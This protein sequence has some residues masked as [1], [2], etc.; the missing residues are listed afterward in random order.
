MDVWATQLLTRDRP[1]VPLQR[2]REPVLI[3]VQGRPVSQSGSSSRQP[4]EGQ[5]TRGLLTGR[6]SCGPEDAQIRRNERRQ[7]PHPVTQQTDKIAPE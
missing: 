3:L 1:L 6:H 2:R 4:G 5:G 7:Q